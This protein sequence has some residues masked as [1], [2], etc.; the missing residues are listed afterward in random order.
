MLPNV[1]GPVVV[2]DTLG[3]AGAIMAES[4]F[5]FLGLGVQEPTPSWWQTLTGAMQLPVLEGM[6]WR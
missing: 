1:V 2:A 4:G 5:S 6:P 3:L